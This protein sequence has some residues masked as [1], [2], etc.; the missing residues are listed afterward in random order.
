MARGKATPEAVHWIIIRLSV[1]MAE[2]EIAMYVDL[3]VR[4]VR[5]ILAYFKIYR[6]V[7]ISTRLLPRPKVYKSLCDY[8]IEARF[9]QQHCL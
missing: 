1:V 5:K 3:S 4:T 2:D 8:D 9:I 7:N 6:D